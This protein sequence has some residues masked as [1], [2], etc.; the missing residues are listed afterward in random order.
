[1]FTLIKNAHIY[2]PE[3]LGI[4]DVLI[5]NNKIVEIKE[6]IEFDYEHEEIDASNKYLV[7][8]FIDQ[9]VHIIGGGGEN[10]FSSLIRELQVSDCVKYG[11]TTVIGLLG[12]DGH[13]KS[14]EQLV[15]KTKA[16]KEHGMSAYCLTGSYEIPTTTLT[17]EVE[18]DID[19]VEEIIGCKVAIDDH[20]CSQPT[21]EE[22]IRL[23]SQCR[24]AGLLSNKVGEVHIHTGRGK[25]GYKKLLEIVEETDLPITQFRPTH[26]ANQYESAL[27]FAGKGGY[28]DFTADV[29]DSKLIAETMNKVD[30]KQ[31][32]MSSDSNGSFPIWS[33]D[34]KIIGMGIGKMETLFSTV[35]EMIVNEHVDITKALSIITCNVADALLL[36]NKGR[37]QK[38]N[39]ADIVLL[40]Q[41]FNITDVW[42]NGNEMI[43]DN[44]VVVKNYYQYDL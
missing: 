8:G 33:K 43:R 12:T 13:V 31:I 37:I 29:N 17:G 39:D 19:F 1:M 2:A 11:V 18:K 40:D 15:A 14:I 7:P 16:L 10:G 28:I 27:E 20:R 32:T 4:H 22:L 21:K 3:D 23:A 9:H 38:D 5:C 30:L 6:H 42:A 41:D 44:K 26:V 36:K 35:K 34:L 25:D 24:I